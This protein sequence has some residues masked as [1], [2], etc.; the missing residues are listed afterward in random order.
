MFVFVV[1]FIWWLILYYYV[2]WFND[3]FYYSLL[4]K[5]NLKIKK[6]YNFYD[7]VKV[8]EIKGN[9]CIYLNIKFMINR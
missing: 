8:I 3:E 4:F 6:F 9:K 5:K 1:K 7:K 2:N